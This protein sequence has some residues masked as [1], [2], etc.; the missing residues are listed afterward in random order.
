[1]T[2]TTTTT[3]ATTTTTMTMTTTTKTTTTTTTTTTTAPTTAP[4]PPTT[5]SK[6]KT[7]TATM[8]PTT[9]NSTTALPTN[10][11]NSGET[12]NSTAVLEKESRL[13]VKIEKSFVIKKI[14][15]KCIFTLVHTCESIGTSGHKTVCTPSK[16]KRQEMKNLKLSGSGFKYTENI[17]VN[18]T[19]IT[20]ISMTSKPSYCKPK[21]SA[22]TPPPPTTAPTTAAQ[23]LTTTT[24]TTTTSTTTSTTIPITSTMLPF[25]VNSSNSMNCDCS[26]NCPNLG[27]DCGCNCGCP[28]P[29]GGPHLGDMCAPGYTRICP[30]RSIFCPGDMIDLCPEDMLGNLAVEN[31]EIPGGMDNSETKSLIT[32]KIFDKKIRISGTTFQCII[33]MVHT[34]HTVKLGQSSIKCTPGNPGG[35]VAKQ[36]EFT[37]NGY[38]FKINANINPTKLLSAKIVGAPKTTTTTTTTTSTTTTSTS[39]T[40]FNYDGCTCL[41]DFVL[42]FSHQAI[43]LNTGLATRVGT[44]NTQWRTEGQVDRSSGGQEDRKTEGQEDR[45]GLGVYSH[46]FKIPVSLAS[47]ELQRA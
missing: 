15:F 29:A 40:L 36:V 44:F 45:S 37:I 8:S 30:R 42:Y 39:T 21:T 26:C 19:K 34:Y 35:L 24:T 14:K 3:T 5:I 12:E 13:S 38:T 28:L 20:K 33:E 32:S 6:S 4:A 23:I 47:R 41:P 25:T 43:N 11:T 17:N 31:R 46:S 1:M 7:T 9:A 22:P 16:P 2:T 27:E 10:I 18:P